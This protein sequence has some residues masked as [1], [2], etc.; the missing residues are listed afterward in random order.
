MLLHTYTHTYTHM[1]PLSFFSK[2]E[3]NRIQNKEKAEI[4]CL[5]CGQGCGGRAHCW[6]PESTL[7]RHLSVF[8][9]PTAASNRHCQIQGTVVASLEDGPFRMY[10]H[11]QNKKPTL[12]KKSTKKKKHTYTN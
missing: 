8:G 7:G 5:R 1:G 6:G 4:I 9:M 10:I 2:P 11:I 12:R 3:P